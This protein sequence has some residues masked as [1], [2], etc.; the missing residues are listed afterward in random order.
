[1][2]ERD[3]EQGGCVGADAA[4]LAG[5]GQMGLNTPTCIKWFDFINVTRD[6]QQVNGVQTIR[7]QVLLYN[8]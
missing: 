8:L 5:W 1:M 3:A 6:V 2:M 7:E 4:N